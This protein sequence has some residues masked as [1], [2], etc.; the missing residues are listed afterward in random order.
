MADS[1]LNR[2]A[3]EILEHFA[4][5]LIAETFAWP[6]VHARDHS[7]PMNKPRPSDQRAPAFRTY[8]TSLHLISG[9]S[10]CVRFHRSG[11]HASSSLGSTVGRFT[12]NWVM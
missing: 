12:S 2:N 4:W 7:C 1:N 11:S 5:R 6:I 10:T 3:R 9:N 8:I